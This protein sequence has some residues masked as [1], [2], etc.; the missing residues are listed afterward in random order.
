MRKLFLLAFILVGQVAFAQKKVVAGPDVPVVDNQV[1]YEKVYDVAGQSQA[2]LY[3]N[4][5]AW[6]V[7]R[8]KSTDE[9]D[10]KDNGTG[11]VLGNGIEFLTF[12]G[13]L[14]RDVSCKIK[15]K[16]EIVSKDGGYKVRIFNIVYGYQGDPTDERVFFSA[17][18]LVKYVSTGQRVKNAAG[19][20]PIPFN[21]KQSA[22]ALESLNPFVDNILT[23][24]NQS[25][26]GK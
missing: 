24:I 1:V 11:K 3:S 14:K 10:S 26:S 22:K 15:M 8:Y 19:V 20:N 12:K 9:I 13:P 2:Q 21:K 25:M 5:Q 18:D 6:F 23:S 7:T 4:A 17:E 16:I